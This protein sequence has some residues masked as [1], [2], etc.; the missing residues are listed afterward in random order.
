M[1]TSFPK[2][3]GAGF[4]ETSLWPSAATIAG[5]AQPSTGSA[6]WVQERCDATP[7]DRYSCVP[8]QFMAERRQSATTSLSPATFAE[9]CIRPVWCPS[10]IIK[11]LPQTSR[12]S[13]R[14]W[15]AVEP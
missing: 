15:N 7:P 8:L 14:E 10:T 9:S 2:L 13:H 12:L 3:V 11:Q 4:S 1:D 6:L 5:R